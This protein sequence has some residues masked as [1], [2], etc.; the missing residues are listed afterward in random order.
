MEVIEG[1]LLQLS[2]HFATDSTGEPV[3]SD[4]M[5]TI[6]EEE[7]KHVKCI[8]NPNGIILYTITGHI[9]KGGV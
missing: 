4:R 1:L 5:I 8:Q 2:S 9:T 6:W 7:K 3:P